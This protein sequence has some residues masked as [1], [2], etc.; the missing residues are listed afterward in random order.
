MQSIKAL[1]YSFDSSK[2]VSC[3]ISGGAAGCLMLPSEIC[4]ITLQAMRG[5][6]LFAP[7]PVMLAPPLTFDKRMGFACSA[8]CLC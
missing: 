2:Q 4:P 7:V 5:A 1:V 6:H 8:I 3:S